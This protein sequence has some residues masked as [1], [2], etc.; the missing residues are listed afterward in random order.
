MPI[1]MSS[2]EAK[3]KAIHTAHNGITPRRKD[4][5]SS[6]ASILELHGTLE[7]QGFQLHFLYFTSARWKVKVSLL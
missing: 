6:D 7:N 3:D 2:Q 4:A 1:G 5:T